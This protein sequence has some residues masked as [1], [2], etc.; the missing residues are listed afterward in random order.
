MSVLQ[1]LR[2]LMPSRPLGD[3]EAR[4]IAER[5][6]ARMLR[7][8]GITEPHVPGS[9]IADLPRIAVDVRSGLPA[10]GVTHWQRSTHTW[11]IVLRAN[12]AAVR[13]RFSLAHELKHIIDHPVVDLA[14][15]ALGRH[16]SRQRA[17]S[18]CDYFAACLLMPRP[19]VK[20]AWASGVQQLD[21][22]AELFGVSQQAMQYRLID[23]GLIPSGRH[24]LYFREAPAPGRP[25][26]SIVETDAAAT[27]SALTP[28]LAA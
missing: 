24:N 13:Q 4:A 27:R 23:C 28:V 14:Y 12:D 10:S 8:T 20:K 25:L 1:E 21:A 17:E 18:I 16:T 11:R 7:L 22:L 9:I 3:S 6:A 19:W 26:L 15:P 5:Q 2:Q